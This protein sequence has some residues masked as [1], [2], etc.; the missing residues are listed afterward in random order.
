MQ[1]DIIL[2]PFPLFS[3][4][5]ALSRTE[6]IRFSGTGKSVLLKPVSGEH[7]ASRNFVLLVT[8]GGTRVN[9]IVYL[10]V[11]QMKSIMER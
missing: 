8:L 5:L 7:C 2:F 1:V 9:L 10:T 11:H 4:L 3:L 6:K